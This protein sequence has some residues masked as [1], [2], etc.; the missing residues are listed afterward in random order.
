MEEEEEEEAV[1]RRGAK[2]WT[3]TRRSPS[4]LRRCGRFRFILARRENRGDPK[5]QTGRE[6]SWAASRFSSLDS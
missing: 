2:A 6:S 5:C 3:E 4:L 1:V